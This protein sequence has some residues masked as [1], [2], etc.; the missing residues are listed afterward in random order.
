MLKE[1]D[2]SDEE[3]RWNNVLALLCK[4][5]EMEPTWKTINFSCSIKAE[6]ASVQFWPGK[7]CLRFRSHCRQSGLN[8][9]FSLKS[10][11]NLLRFGQL[12][13]HKSHKS[14][15]VQVTSN[16]GSESDIYW[17]FF[18]ATWSEQPAFNTSLTSFWSNICDSS[19]EKDIIIV[20]IK[21][22]DSN[23]GVSQ[24]GDN[25]DLEQN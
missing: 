13:Q 6:V 9:I 12:E 16:Y 14:N 25:K 23:S 5:K 11:L 19:V 4:L 2:A 7:L 22:E 17:I 18:N 15:P 20:M 8:Q 1:V 21:K 24:W 10:D 3:H